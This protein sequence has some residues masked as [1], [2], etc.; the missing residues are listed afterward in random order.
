[1]QLPFAAFMPKS[2]WVAPK[3]A[4]LPS[5]KDAK[6][7]AFDLESHDPGLYETGCGAR[8]SDA[9]VCGVSFKIDDDPRAYYLPTRHLD[10]GNLPE[11]AVWQYVRDQMAAFQGELLGA[12]NDYDMDW[13]QTRYGVKYNPAIRH[14]N[15]LTTDSLIWEHH[16]RYDLGS[17]AQRR[18]LGGKDETLLEQAAAHYGVHRKSGLSRMHA[19][20]V[21]AYA[22]QDVVLPILIRKHQMA[23]LDRDS[24]HTADKLESD[25]L[26]IMVEMRRIGVLIDQDKLAQ[27]E[28]W[29]HQSQAVRLAQVAHVSGIQMTMKDANSSGAMARIIEKL[30]LPKLPSTATGKPSIAGEVLES[31]KHPV[32]DLIREAR[33]FDK[34]KTTYIPE[35]KACM[36]NGRIHATLKSAKA[37]RDDG[38]KQGTISRRFSC[39]NPNLQNQ[40]NPGKD[41]RVL[42]VEIGTRWRSIFIPE[43]GC[44]WALVDF[45]QQEPRWI[46]HHAELLGFDKAK[47]MA[48]AFRNDATTDNH[49]MIAKITG[50]PRGLA[51]IIF[52]AR[53]YGAGYAKIAQQLEEFGAITGN[54]A[55]EVAHY[56]GVTVTR[57]Y[58]KGDWIPPGRAVGESYEDAVPPIKALI[59]QFD[60]YAPYVKELARFC[61]QRA[62]KRKYIM[63]PDG[64]RLHFEMSGPFIIDGHKALNKLAQGSAAI[65][66]KM[67]LVALARAGLIPQMAVH[68]DFSR[69]ITHISEGKR[70]RDICRDA[71][72][73]NVPFVVKLK[74]GPSY[75][76]ADAAKEAA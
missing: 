5:W 3:M 29:I 44:T 19:K 36:V 67:A 69:S 12:E 7:I 48:E 6:T 38:K 32:I 70:M 53:C 68:D 34:L 23:E 2:D 21:G 20:Y 46:V 1:M 27:A 51:K 54:L 41:D 52:L 64:G 33:R 11:E 63:L 15:V 58:Q 25:V 24:L 75:G 40:P 57:Y 43:P 62:E 16:N 31:Y 50:L 10:G 17:V 37:T 28:T 49:T 73:A 14:Y 74:L 18:G 76:E 47:E 8:R 72:K 39:V 9:Y 42:T 30:G 22:E 71:I 4:S 61:T 59:Q 60:T 56:G 35:I 13:V 66:A 55:D 45:S 65:Q 26:P